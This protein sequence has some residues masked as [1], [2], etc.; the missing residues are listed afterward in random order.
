MKRHE[1]RQLILE[2]EGLRVEFKRKFSS[3]VKFAKEI[4]AFANTK[5]GV[6]LVGVDDNGRI[7]GVDSEKEQIELVI[8]AAEFYLEPPVHCRV[9]CVEVDWKEVV[10]IYVDESE[11]KPHMLKE[12]P[13]QPLERDRRAYIRNADQSVLASKEM[14]R[15]LSGRNPQTR[16]M[17][18]HIGDREKRL[19][20]FLEEHHRITVKEFANLVNISLRRSSQI[21]VRLVRAEVLNI[22]T[23]TTDEYF[24]LAE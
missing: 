16:P 1:L 2:G 7:V 18:L 21:L 17:T 10:V 8:S 13:D 11:T 15:L 22:C 3:H 6:L 24:T 23:N 9:E 12:D 19:F 4:S 5:G 14:M 20:A